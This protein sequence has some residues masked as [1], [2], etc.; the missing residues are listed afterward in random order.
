MNPWLLAL[1]G[2]GAALW[3]ALRLSRCRSCGIPFTPARA[4]LEILVMDGTCGRCRRG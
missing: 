4:F 3:G 1:L 2:L